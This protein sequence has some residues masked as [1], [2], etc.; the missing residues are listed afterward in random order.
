MI[1]VFQKLAKEVVFMHHV[2]FSSDLTEALAWPTTEIVL[3]TLKE[4]ADRAEFQETLQKL[5]AQLEKDV[6]SSELAMG[7]WGPVIED[8]RKF[9]VSHGWH[10]LEVSTEIA[11]TFLADCGCS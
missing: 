5:L 3:C 4:S 9:M 2:K 6:P 7:G 11:C 8:E 10:S 1:E